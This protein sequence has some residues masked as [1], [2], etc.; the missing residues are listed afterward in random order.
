MNNRNDYKGIFY[1]DNSER[2]YY[3]G[4]AHFSY[5]ALYQILKNIKKQQTLNENKLIN[6]EKEITRQV[7]II[8]RQKNFSMKNIFSCD[9]QIKKNKIKKKNSGSHISNI[10]NN[11]NNNINQKKDL[12]LKKN[13]FYEK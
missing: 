4:G 12:N 10:N 11:N 3:E 5:E 8:S 13:K 2:K 7:P 9:E 1:E 6:K